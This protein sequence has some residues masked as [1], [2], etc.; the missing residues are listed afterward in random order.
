MRNPILKYSFANSLYINFYNNLLKHYVMNIHVGQEIRR[1]L[2][3]KNCTV[4]W[5]AHQLSCS[6]TNMYKIFEK[7]HLDSE[8]LQRISVALDYDF[9]ALLSYQL[10][11]EEGISDPT[12]HRNSII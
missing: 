7:P 6:R 5:L 10:R 8:M 1:R 12:F 4:V 9:F 11:K 2:E 3:E